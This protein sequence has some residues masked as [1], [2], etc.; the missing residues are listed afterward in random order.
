MSNHFTNLSSCFLTV[1]TRLEAGLLSV[2]RSNFYLIDEFDLNQ[3]A[4]VNFTEH[5]DF[6]CSPTDLRTKEPE[7]HVA[8]YLIRTAY[9][10]CVMMKSERKKQF[11]AKKDTL[12][13]PKLE[14][15][16]FAKERKR[17]QKKTFS[18]SLPFNHHFSM[19]CTITSQLNILKE[20]KKLMMIGQEMLRY[21][22]LSWW[23][24]R[25]WN[26]CS[27]MK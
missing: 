13:F 24:Q 27:K 8:D 9:S 26:T 25:C 12:D 1:L 22:I 21:S 2:N 14:A 23:H 16:N 15:K 5:G 10:S 7:K 6:K 11:D 3:Q 18:I 19:D 20:T 4:K 17:N